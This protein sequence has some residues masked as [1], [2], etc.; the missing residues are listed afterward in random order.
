MLQQ[1]LP[2]ATG[3]A[4]SM[5]VAT[6]VV[7]QGVVRQLS[8]VSGAAASAASSS[9]GGAAADADAAGWGVPELLRMRA[10]ARPSERELP[11]TSSRVRVLVG[12]LRSLLASGAEERVLV[13][14]QWAAHVTHV[15]ETLS[16]AGVPSAT[17][18]WK[19]WSR[20][21]SSSQTFM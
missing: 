10:A 16:A 3:L 5:V 20:C 21:R 6:A 12:L 9:A 18:C 7:V 4:G 15:G 1:A 8:G 11:G 2:M 17:S 19:N 13:F 14:A